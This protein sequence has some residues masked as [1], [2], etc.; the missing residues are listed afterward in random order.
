[1]M[2]QQGL[3]D[4]DDEAWGTQRTNEV[5]Y[6][7]S[8][9]LICSQRALRRGTVSETHPL[10]VLCHVTDQPRRCFAPNTASP[11]LF[12]ARGAVYLVRHLLDPSRPSKMTRRRHIA[13]HRLLDPET[14][15][16]A[17]CTPHAASSTSSTSNDPPKTTRRVSPIH[18]PQPPSSSK[19]APKRTERR[20]APHTPPPTLFSRRRMTTLVVVRV[21]TPR[22]APTAPRL[23]PPL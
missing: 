8:F 19:R 12:V 21:R 20:C 3:E 11:S 6:T 18:R 9:V 14:H 4:D 22:S 10:L 15:T 16:E 2:R 7:T 17:A 23:Y 1:M 13:P 5:V